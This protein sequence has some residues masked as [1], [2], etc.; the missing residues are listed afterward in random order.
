V[1]DSLRPV[2]LTGTT[3]SGKSEL[4]VRIA[5]RDGGCV[6]NADAAQVY[7]C[8]R[9]LTARPGAAELA[10]APHALYGHVSC[11]TRYSVGVWLRDIE[12]ALADAQRR[13]LRPVIVGGTGLYISA[14]TEGLSDIPQ[15][16][17]EI[18]ARSAGMLR[19]GRVDVMLAELERR[20][21]VTLARLDRGNPRRVQ[22]AW[23][24]LLA[25]GRGLSEWHRATRPPLLPAGS[26]IRLVIDRETSRL[27][28]LITDRFHQMLE[29][30][31][32]DE[33][34]R[35]L[36]AGHAADAPAGR[37]LG[38]EPLFACLREA[39]TLDAAAAAAVTATRQFAKRQRTWFRHRMADWPRV[40]P[41]DDPLATVPR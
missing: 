3:A 16:P 9:V 27:N 2:V 22:R 1:S 35:F 4:A 12:A 15:I 34:R 41:A 39:M 7:S 28:R 21:P 38:A 26:A 31:A 10:R 40:D 20:D 8:W 29:D 30:G 5:E 23:E 24:V 11:D 19:A 37:V 13:G 33:C 18:R 25:T 6:I 17:A 14:L 32:L 36:A